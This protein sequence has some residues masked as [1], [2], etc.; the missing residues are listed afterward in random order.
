VVS[1]ETIWN[2]CVGLHQQGLLDSV[3]ANIAVQKDYFHRIDS[4]KHFYI[5]TDT[6]KLKDGYYGI[7]YFILD[8]FME[9]QGRQIGYWIYYYPTGKV[10]AEGSYAIGAYTECQAGGPM[11][12]GYSIKTGS[13]VYRHENKQLMAKGSYA[14]INRLANRF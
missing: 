6:L 3:K 11:I 9:Y 4:V 1:A 8:P 14:L 13:W 12:I 10:Y 5:Y 2:K 7:G